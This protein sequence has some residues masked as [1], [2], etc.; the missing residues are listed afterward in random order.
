M[1]I[2]SLLAPLLLGGVL[3][4]SNPPHIAKREDKN[5]NCT[6]Y[7]NTSIALIN[8]SWPK[9]TMVRRRVVYETTKRL[10]RYDQTMWDY[11]WK[12]AEGQEK[13]KSVPI[14]SNVLCSIFV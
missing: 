13:S 9:N 12:W 4:K 1:R 11:G 14:L 10:D 5:E 6:F 8:I 7:A 3:A 2:P